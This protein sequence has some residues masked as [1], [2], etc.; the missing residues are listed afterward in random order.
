MFGKLFTQI[1]N[2][3]L[4]NWAEN[5]GVYVESQGGFRAGFGTTDSIF[6][7]HNLITWCLNNKKKLYS[8]FVDYQ[9]AFDYVVRD[10]L[11]YKLLKVGVR[12]K[13]YNIIRSMYKSVSST[14]KGVTEPIQ[15]VLGVRQ[16]ESL[17]PFL[18]AIY[19]NDLEDYMKEKGVRG[20]TIDTLKLFVL[21]YADDAVLFSDT[22]A[23]LQEGLDAL[24]EY[25]QR[26]KLKLNTEKS[27][28]VVFR[29]GGQ[30]SR[31]DRWSYNGV[32]LEIVNVFNYLGL[33][34][35]Y[36]GS[37]AKTQQ[38]L[39]KQARKAVFSLKKT[40]SNF[41]GLDHVMLCDLFDKLVLPILTYS[42]EVW[43]FHQSEAIE[44]VHREF[45]RSILKVKATTMNEFLYGELG[46]LPLCYIRY[47]RIV[48]YWFKIV[49][50]SENRLIKQVYLVQKR[51]FETND[52]VINWVSLVKDLLCRYGFG[53]VWLQQ[54]VGNV[55][56]FLTCFKQ[57][58]KDIY[59]QVWNNHIQESRKAITY[60]HIVQSF[61]PQFYL[62]NIP[63]V[64][65][66]Y[67]MVNLRLRNNRLRVETGS[68]TGPGATT[69]HQ[70]LCLMCEENQ[71]EDEYHFV[72]VC[73]YY[74][75]LRCLHIPRYYR[76]RPS[77]QKFVNLMTTENIKLL[78]KLSTFVYKA[79]QK[80]SHGT[81]NVL[82]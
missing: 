8:V 64:Q 6:V 7:L 67:A 69:Y 29:A 54:G 80:R 13:M 52:R 25:C 70:R 16:G 65:Y 49:E 11:W 75:E 62:T 50:S 2:A 27:K 76:A 20:L 72:M 14:I 66:K 82:P 31:L 36:T 33:N 77:M 56:V 38:L 44:R 1:L 32:P 55:D 68:W 30:L 22:R 4:T 18:F 57:R 79:L 41:V 78:N 12:G 26:W 15:C 58:M 42:C 21:F 3:R 74:A 61:K 43:G 63:R 23:G 60:K 28:V 37:F 10:N 17:S 71:I 35:S 46:R 40:A 34:L 39:A 5:Y 73:V 24:T 19:V 9:K 59:C 45:M 47:A 81:N 48:K 53:N 51:H